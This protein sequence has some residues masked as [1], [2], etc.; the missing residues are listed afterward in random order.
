MH[1]WMHV[2]NDKAFYCKP[3]VH[4]SSCLP[5]VVFWPD[6]SLLLTYYQKTHTHTRMVQDKSNQKNHVY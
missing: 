2:S 6:Q 1:V 4:I 5:V 3:Q